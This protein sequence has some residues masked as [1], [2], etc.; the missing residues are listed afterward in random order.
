MSSLPSPLKSPAYH[1]WLPLSALVQA[2]WRRNDEPL[3]RNMSAPDRSATLRKMSS[4]P[5]P[6]KSPTY[7]VPQLPAPVQEPDARKDEPFE[8]NMSAPERPGQYRKMS[9]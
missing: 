1:P 8:R 2:P 4:L 9:S 5:S 7:H 3:E 6:S